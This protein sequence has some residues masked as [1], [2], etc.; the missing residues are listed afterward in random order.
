MIS[1]VSARLKAGVALVVTLSQLTAGPRRRLLW[2]LC[3]EGGFEI[4]QQIVEGRSDP[5]W[6]PDRHHDGKRL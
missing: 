2:I 6:E 3:R 4:V 5:R 1:K